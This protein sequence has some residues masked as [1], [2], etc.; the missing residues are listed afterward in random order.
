MYRFQYFEEP[1]SAQSPFLTHESL[2]H[3]DGGFVASLS[4]SDE[5]EFTQPFIPTQFYSEFLTSF[6][7]LSSISLQDVVN[8]PSKPTEYDYSVAIVFLLPLAGL[9]IR[10]EG[11]DDPFSYNYQKFAAI[12]IMVIMLGQGVSIPGLSASL[13]YGVAFAEEMEQP[14]DDTGLEPFTL[15]PPIVSLNFDTQN[16]ESLSF[17]SDATITS[18]ANPSLYLDGLNDY[19]K[20]DSSSTNELDYLTVSGWVKPDYSGGSPVFAV[21]SKD[22]SFML[23]I[24]N[25]ISP[26]RKVMFSVF[27]GI[28]WHSV[29]SQSEINEEWTHLAA[30]FGDS[31]ISLYVNGKLEA[32]N[33]NEVRNSE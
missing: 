15:P 12:T 6:P 9:I 2:V 19:A 16:F 28:R 18:D 27:D 32:R 5:S 13:Y 11:K 25:I 31:S 21:L 14:T 3:L 24:N 30:T 1:I 23:T 10:R 17:E 20:Y 4:N 33:G 8:D 29:Q 7:F 26:E 22:K